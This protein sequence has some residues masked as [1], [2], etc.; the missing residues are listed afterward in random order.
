M[1]KYLLFLLLVVLFS[2]C[3]REEAPPIAARFSVELQGESHTTP[4]TLTIK[5]ESY[6]AEFYEWTFEGGSPSSSRE[7]QPGSVTFTEP[8]ELTLASPFSMRLG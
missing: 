2:A 4:L 7:K 1:I 8:G 5:N 6:G 3:L